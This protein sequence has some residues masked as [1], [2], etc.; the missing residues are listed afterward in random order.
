M[1]KLKHF[2]WV[3]FWTLL[4]LVALPGSV[5]LAQSHTVSGTVVNAKS[6]PLAG[7]S[8][9]VN[10]TS[11]VVQADEKGTFRITLPAEKASL[12]ISMVGYGSKTIQVRSGESV[13]VVLI[14][15]LVNMDE[16]IIV[17]YGKQ[18]KSSLTGS[19]AQISGSELKK[20]PAINLSNVLAGRLP[21]LTVLQ[22]SGRPGFDEAT[23][24]IRGIN[25]T[26][27]TSP[28]IV[29]DGVQRSFSQ[30]DPNEIENISILKDAA[31]AA[32]YGLQAAGGVILVTTKRGNN[33]KATVSYD[34][35]VSRNSFT[36]FPKFLNGPDYMHW[37]KKG[38]ELDNEYLMHI[39]ADPIPYTYTDEE[40]EALRNGSN[41]N[42]FYGNTDWVKELL[43]HNS[44]TQHHNL[45]VR[46]GN[47]S[48]KYFTS[49]GMLNQEG[50]VKD[51]D[52]KR[53]NV[54][55]NLDFTLSNVF[56]ASI[57]LGARKED[58]FSTGI[59]ADNGAYMN[60]F[61]QAV[62]AL[63]N[64]P[65]YTEDGYP[66]ASRA[67]AGVVNP[68]AAIEKSGYQRYETSVLNSNISLNAKIPWVKGLTAKILVGY[69]RSGQEFKSWLQPYDLMVRE[70][71]SSGWF[72]SKSFPP[73]ITVNTLRQSLSNSTRQTLQPQIN[74][75]NRFGDH[76]IKA[77]AVYEFSKTDGNS[78]STGARN[79]SLS[80]IHEITFGSKDPLDF[81]SPTGG[82]DK[83]ARAGYVG[84]LNYGY[85]DKYLAELVARYD[86]SYNF[87]PENRWGLFPAASLGWM[88]SKENFFEKFSNAVS[89]LKLR[90]SA[91]LLGNDRINELQYLQ[92]FSLT[93]TPVVVFGGSP[94]SA[95]FT[96]GIPNRDITWETTS[97]FNVGLEISLW[98]GKLDI[99][100]DYFYKVT[101]DIL[102][103]AGNLYPL[104]VG[105]NY[106]SVVNRSIVDNRGFDLR[107]VHRNKLGRKF[108]YNVAGNFNF[109]KNR[110]I[111]RDIPDGTPEWQNPLGRSLGLKQGYISEGLFQS[112][113]EVNNWPFS[114]AGTA[115]PGFIKYRDLNGDGMITQG[116]DFAFIGKSNFPEI[117]YGLNIDLQ[118]GAFDLSALLQGA[119]RT[120]VSLGGTYEGSVGV[121]GVMDNTP[122]TRSFYNLG[123]S[124]YYLIDQAWRPDNPT[125]TLPRLTANRAGYPN[126]N[127][128]MNS[129]YVV[130]GSYLRLKTLQI[131]FTVPKP[132]L[133]RIKVQ[134]IR[135]YLAGFNLLTWDHL[136]YLDPEMPNANNGFYPQQK[137]LTFGTNITF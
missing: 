105:G 37:Y 4:A 7:A 51:N 102:E 112:W 136:K 116:G 73:G 59:A 57:D 53:Y 24:R 29:V 54:R 45:S 104:S 66:V 126:H 11:T 16:V 27:V 17:G 50:V 137:M 118:Y 115:A 49:I 64:L 39:S 106:P 6:E 68:I 123:N 111:R 127:G 76:D 34:A 82:S 22:Q 67:G 131:G 132:V 91:G 3:R 81:I 89:M 31:A 77:L 15:E 2:L 38:E 109:A 96:S 130:N 99:E 32:V 93:T 113:D 124:P 35:S 108:S 120:D 114:P 71:A 47:E 43:G 103:S 88:V 40:I 28:I 85:K 100:A 9:K 79:F 25:T 1:N 101:R 23:L 133:D 46:G 62:R 72:W 78:F 121:V 44:M 8:I 90:A 41:T 95:L 69:D 70:R 12:T 52:F 97:T 21:G 42:P 84:R 5:V 19:V 55:T 30:L 58:R 20:A 94:V 122:F 119:A 13:Q 26:G 74:Y 75:E 83:T 60:P 18:K 117:M 56:S 110:L 98:N 10:G 128:W 14:E 63:P 36:R 87:P 135:F 65:M 61:F 80:D 33:R 86:A 48:V 129:Q 125:A 92:T 134:N 107:L